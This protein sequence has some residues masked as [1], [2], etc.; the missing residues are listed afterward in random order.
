MLNLL[1]DSLQQQKIQDPKRRFN[2]IFD[3]MNLI[4]RHYENNPLYLIHFIIEC[5]KRPEINQ[6]VFVAHKDS[7]EDSIL[8]QIKN[9]I[10]TV[11][12]IND[13]KMKQNELNMFSKLNK[14]IL[15]FNLK[16]DHRNLKSCKVLSHVRT[17]VYKVNDVSI[18]I[19][20]KRTRF[21]L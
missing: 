15:K 3:N 2:L 21:Y 14:Q 12:Y 18:K 17:V 9:I 5:T 13:T 20:L 6:I 8:N 16:I 7:L 4:L 1:L 10:Q 11:I 19:F